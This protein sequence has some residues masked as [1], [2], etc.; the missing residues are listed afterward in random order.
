[1]SDALLHFAA[2]ASAW[3]IAAGPAV[4]QGQGLVLERKPEARASRLE[5]PTLLR[6][7]RIEGIGDREVRAEGNAE[8][9]RGE[10]SIAADSL[11]FNNETGDVEA[12]GNVRLE[13]GGQVITGPYMK[14]RTTDSTGLLESPDFT[15]APRTRLGIEAVTGR[16]H[17]DLVQIEGEDRFRL[18]NTTFTTCEPGNDDWYLRIRELS[19]DYGRDVGVASWATVYFMG[20]PV[21][22]TPYL[23]FG[24]QNRRKSGLLPPTIGTT[25]KSGPEL[26]LPYYFNLAPNYDL[27]FVPRYMAKR[28]LQLGGELR[29]LQPWYSGVVK[30][31]TLPEDEVRGGTRSAV[32]LVQVYNRGPVAAAFNLNKVTDNDYFRDLSSRVASVSQT[33]LPREG[34][35]SYTGTWSEGGLWSATARFQTFQVLQDVNDPVRTPYSRAPQVVLN[36]Q[37][38]DIRGFD[39]FFTGEAVDFHHPTQVVGVRTLMYPSLALPLL[40]PGLFITPKLGVHTTRYA[41][42]RAAAGTPPSI[43]RTVPIFSTDA[44]LVFE[45]NARYFGESFLQTLEPR[46]Y[47]LNIPFKDQNNIPVFDTAA[48]D[49]NYAQIFSENSFVGGDRINDANQITLAL[50]SRLLAPA[51]GQ[52]TLR[53]TVAQRLYFREQRVTLNAL[54]PPRKFTESDW[55]ASIAG[56]LAPRWT[57]E[58]ALQYNPREGR[59]ERFN[60]SSRYQP[61]PLKTLNMG[62]RFQRDRLSHI[63]LSAQWPLGG[64]WHG[65]GRYNY[66][67]R[68]GRLVESLAGFE[69]N[70]G[71]WIGRFVAQRFASAAGVATNALFVQLE[72][73]GFSRIGSNPLEVLRRNIPGYTNINSPFTTDRAFEPGI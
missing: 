39:F 41:V 4:A 30:A 2:L 73:K 45:R 40:T 68:D 31:E 63:D 71:C 61:E 55:L 5:L 50:T 46:A 21:L 49:F 47:Y 48:A 26:T 38:P 32:S 23:D 24:L 10:S 65:V 37:R 12:R 29:Y 36:A 67:L 54:T 66:S 19:L 16:G 8:L 17:A 44:G 15:F 18:F 3:L 69:Y 27:T 72:L 13:H 11:R 33:Y 52:E 58:T 59:N 51:N 1:M 70:G 25:G 42:T 7:D 14:Y 64:P 57:L 28:G 22:V 34:I 6:A 60:V 56:R 62:Y 9:Q 43:G 53:A 20:A 35:A